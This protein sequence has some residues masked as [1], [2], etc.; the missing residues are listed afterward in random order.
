MERCRKKGEWIM[1]Q[2]FDPMKNTPE[3]EMLAHARELE[4]R[5]TKTDD[6]SQYICDGCG[7]TDPAG[8]EP[9]GKCV[10]CRL[11]RKTNKKVMTGVGH[12][13]DDDTKEKSEDTTSQILAE[14][15]II[16]KYSQESSVESQVPQFMSL[17]GG[18]PAVRSQGYGT[19]GIIPAMNEAPSKKT[20]SEVYKMPAVSQ[21]GY[22]KNS[23]SLHMHLNDGGVNKN[24]PNRAPIEESLAS[25]KKSSGEGQMG[26][27][28][29]ITDLLEKIYTH[30]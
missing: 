7:K 23:S 10:E 15:G 5:F 24:N 29:D 25:I 11:G 1:P 30:L 8:L 22:D 27:V 21:T 18:K 13:A 26:V 12:F 20:I 14:H 28:S 3:G 17:S 2:W 9:S 6:K 19:N 16:A 4:A